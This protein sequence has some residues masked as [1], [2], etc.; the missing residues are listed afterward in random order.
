[1]SNYQPKVDPEALVAGYTGA[2]PRFI[3]QMKGYLERQTP[4]S[5]APTAAIRDRKNPYLKK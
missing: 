3:G 1:M 2:D 4:E 5:K